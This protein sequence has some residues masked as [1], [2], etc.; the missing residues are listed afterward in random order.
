MGLLNI[1]K[2]DYE[3]IDILELEYRLRG[4]WDRIGY[5][6]IYYSKSKNKYKFKIFNINYNQDDL[7]LQVMCEKR[8][9]ELKQQNLNNEKI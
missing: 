7:K 4:I 5:G 1:F 9:I 2:S 8:I 3:L 6:K